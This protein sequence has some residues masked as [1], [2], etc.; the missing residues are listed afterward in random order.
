MHVRQGIGNRIVDVS[1]KVKQQGH[2]IATVMYDPEEDD[3]VIV[4]IGKIAAII[5]VGD[6]IASIV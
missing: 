3:V 5:D 4:E 2:D 1:V 6:T